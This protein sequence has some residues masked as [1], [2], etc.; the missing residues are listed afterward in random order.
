[1]PRGLFITFEGGEGV[2]KTT[3]IKTLQNFLKT[4]GHDVVLTREPGGCPAAEDIR[5]LIFQSDYAEQWTPQAETLLMYAARDMHIKE[6]IAPALDAGKTVLCDR[7]IDSTRV[8]QGI[9]KGVDRQFIAGLEQHIAGNAMPDMTV[10]LDLTA[11]IA[12][13]RVQGRGAENHHDRGDVAFY[14]KLR[15]GFLEIAKANQDRCVIVNADN[16]IDEIAAQIKNLVE[17][18]I[19]N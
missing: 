16:E 6:V 4:Q 10:I 14:E 5:A 11:E 18:K 8:Y 15:Q 12:M 9:V 19:S 2:G 3:Q 17:Q 7:Y 13:M 1:M